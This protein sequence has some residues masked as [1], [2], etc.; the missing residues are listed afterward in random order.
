MIEKNVISKNI[1]A[2][3]VMGGKNSDLVIIKDN[4]ITDS[5]NDGICAIEC[6]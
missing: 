4:D 6:N 3:I 2:N 1:R 5:K